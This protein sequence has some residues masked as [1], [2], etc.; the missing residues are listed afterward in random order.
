MRMHGQAHALSS[1]AD[2][3]AWRALAEV[4]MHAELMSTGMSMSGGRRVREA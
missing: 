4:R 2:V 3:H 1:Y